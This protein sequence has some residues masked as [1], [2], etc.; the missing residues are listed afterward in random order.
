MSKLREWLLPIAYFSNNLIS[1]VGILLVTAATVFWIFLLPQLLRGSTSNAYIGIL[2]FFGLP[3]IFILGLVLIPVGVF[4]ARRKA[5]AR[6]QADPVIF[7]F[8]DIAIRRLLL[9][10]ALATAINIVIVSQLSY[11]AVR[12]METSKFCGQMCHVMNPQFTAYQ[13]STHSAVACS[14]CHV[15]TGA[16]GFVMAK[17]AGTRQL[18]SLTAGTY[19]RPI[20]APDKLP[21]ASE[22][23][24]R[25]HAP[26]RF[27]G[28]RLVIHHEFAEDESNTLA[29]TVLRMKVG[30][31]K[32]GVGIHGTHMRPGARIEFVS[33]GKEIPQVSYI[34]P[35]GK[36]TTYKSTDSKLTPAQIAAGQ[37][38]GMDCVDCHNRAGHVFEVPERA[39][40]R[41]LASGQISPS[42]PFVKREA[43]AA[44][45]G[46]YPDRAAA[47]REIE[48]KLTG[49]LSQADSQRVKAAV[50][51]VQAIYARNVFPEM[52]VSWGTYPNN[53]GHND[54]P[55]CFRCHDG[56]H[57][58]TDGRVISNDCATCHEIP[59]MQEKNPRILTDLGMALADPVSAQKN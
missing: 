48:S 3:A 22:T 45:K 7:D 5:H 14:E 30:G 31:G 13:Q 23:C 9:F 4:F 49:K 50:A 51:A 42:L 57:A 19:P 58:S 20:P 43:L 16:S 46:D 21:A 59:A 52:R 47:L 36:A 35:S 17:L 53:T 34:D 39:L 26:E 18:V 2:L 15:G 1:R 27:V 44:L 40:D 41:A 12:Y 37:S 29:T 10:I 24:Q 32:S 6:G 55:G 33:A 25:C 8:R 11:S 54:S 28:D 56:N 38:R